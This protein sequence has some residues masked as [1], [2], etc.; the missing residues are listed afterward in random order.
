[1]TA[2]NSAPYIV[3]FDPCDDAVQIAGCIVSSDD[4][5]LIGQDDDGLL[6][7]TPLQVVA[8]ICA[9]ETAGDGL[10][11]CLISTDANNALG[12]GAGDGRLFVATLTG[13]E[14]AD[15][16][17]ADD[18]AGDTLAA[19]LISTDPDNQLAQGTDGR[20]LVPA[21][22]NGIVVNSL[23]ADADNG[24]LS[25]PG[26]ISTPN[27]PTV[28]IPQDFDG[29]P[30]SGL[31]TL[32]LRGENQQLIGNG[33]VQYRLEISIDSGATWIPLR[34]QDVVRSGQAPGSLD[35]SNVRFESEIAVATLN[36]LGVGP[37]TA[38][39]VADP[40]VPF[41]PGSFVDVGVEVSYISGPEY[42]GVVA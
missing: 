32:A 34:T 36:G 1:M 21:A 4:G 5:N 24:D 38:R 3:E 8:A 2:R 22:F 17:C 25:Q 11:G 41:E 6:L 19:C 7:T 31:V 10:A 14:M 12:Q 27:I 16:I 33:E 37:V 28:N 9:D 23:Q 20:L 35:I 30:A 13:Q 29:R 40:V 15:A 42:N 18:A 26:Q 39:A